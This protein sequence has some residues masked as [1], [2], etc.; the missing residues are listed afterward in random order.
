ME[1][2]NI[3]LLSIALHFATSNGKGL[4]TKRP[5]F[6]STSN[7]SNTINHD[8]FIESSPFYSNE[9][10]IY[11]LVEHFLAQNESE[12]AL[13]MLRMIIDRERKWR[14]KL[15][16]FLF[17]INSCRRSGKIIEPFSIWKKILVHQLLQD[18]TNEVIEQIR[19][20]IL[21]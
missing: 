14:M 2:Q 1:I 10:Q 9:K 8:S 20:H 6:I 11:K 12:K 15:C 19:R 13:T 16:D 21:L 18:P 4:Q 5:L 7:I 17:G 3:L